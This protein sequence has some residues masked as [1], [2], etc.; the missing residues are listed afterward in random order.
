MS[1]DENACD[2]SHPASCCGIIRKENRDDLD[3]CMMSGSFIPELE[4]SIW[5]VASTAFASLDLISSKAA[6]K[7]PRCGVDQL[8]DDVDSLHAE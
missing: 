2:L 6:S 1:V 4:N 5:S 3:D 8:R 7:D